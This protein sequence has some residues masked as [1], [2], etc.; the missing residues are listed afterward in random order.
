MNNGLACRENK[1]AIFNGKG[2][3]KGKKANKKEKETKCCSEIGKERNKI[4]YTDLRK[5]IG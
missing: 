1:Y 2:R 5:I 3:N 4:L